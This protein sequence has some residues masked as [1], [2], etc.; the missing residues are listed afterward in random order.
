MGRVKNKQ[1]RHDAV[2]NSSGKP[3]AQE[4]KASCHADR[5]CRQE[6]QWEGLSQP[7]SWLAIYRCSRCT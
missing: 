6:W 3:E 7:V 2:R 1:V 4:G 5:P